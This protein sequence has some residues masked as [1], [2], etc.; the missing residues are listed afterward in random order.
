[1]WLQTI[2]NRAAIRSEAAQNGFRRRI[3]NQ[4]TDNKKTKRLLSR[5]ET[6]GLMGVAA[7]AAA[8]AV[9]VGCGDDDDAAR[10]GTATGG[11]ATG[12]AEATTAGSTASAV[13]TP[14]MT[15]AAPAE[16]SCVITPEVTEGPYFVDE[17][18]LRADIRSD[19]TTGEV[20][21]GVPLAITM[22]AASIARFA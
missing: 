10:E 14:A 19:P 17:R 8:L 3:T 6:L 11:T 20:S 21:E 5:R 9:T 18:L 2:V 1:M 15:T 22:T 7:G 16:V 13:Q 12:T 4:M